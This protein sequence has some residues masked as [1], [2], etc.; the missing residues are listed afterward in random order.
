MALNRNTAKKIME[1]PLTPYYTRHGNTYFA[2][3][4]Y[5]EK[6]RPHGTVIYQKLNN[7]ENEKP[8]FILYVPQ[9]GPTRLK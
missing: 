6:G 7:V 2:V 3:P 9:N 5:D 1:H 8:E 4:V